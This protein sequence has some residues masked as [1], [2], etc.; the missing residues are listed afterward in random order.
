MDSHSKS[1]LLSDALGGVLGHLGVGSL[2]PSGTSGV[3]ELGCCGEQSSG[4]TE[5]Q[6]RIGGSL[7][8]EVF[9]KFVH[10]YS[11]SC[12][13]SLCNVFYTRAP[14]KKRIRVRDS[15]E[16]E[17]TRWSRTSWRPSLPCVSHAW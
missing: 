17:I 10:S 15:L 16:A 9:E 4:D 7:T 2:A 5:G 8:L 11:F 13:V 14:Q 1:L 6:S 3:D 12:R